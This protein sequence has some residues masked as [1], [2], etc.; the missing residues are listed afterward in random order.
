MVLSEYLEAEVY[1]FKSEAS[2]FHERL[3]NVDRKK[4]VY[5]DHRLTE[6]FTF[7]RSIFTQIQTSLTTTKYIL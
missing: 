4:Y 7:Y 2:R 3:Q 1:M 6:S 5:I